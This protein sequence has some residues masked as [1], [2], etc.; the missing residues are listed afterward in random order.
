[1]GVCGQY[2]FC[3]VLFFESLNRTAVVMCLN[4]FFLQ[5]VSYAYQVGKVLIRAVQCVVI[6]S[7]TTG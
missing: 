4:E 3:F 1:M 5:V 6:G 7:D 2:L